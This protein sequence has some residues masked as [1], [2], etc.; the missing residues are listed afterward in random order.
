MA[1]EVESAAGA[2]RGEDSGACVAYVMKVFPRLSETFVLNEI[3]AVERLG[4]RVV[5]CSLHRPPEEL[6]HGVLSELTSPVHYIEDCEP[7]SDEDVLAALQ[8]LQRRFG[9]TREERK[10]FL[11][12]KYVRLALSLRSLLDASGVE[13]VHAHF[14]SRAGHVSAI[15]AALS[16]VPYSI[17]A[18]AKDIYHD[19]VD[20]EVLAWKLRSARFVVTVSDY[21]LRHLR[22]LLGPQDGARVRR[23]Y[24]GVDLSRFDAVPFDR[25]RPG[26]ILGVGRLVEKKGFAVLVDACRILRDRGVAFSCEII[27]G[28]AEE[29]GLRKQIESARLGSRVVLTGAVETEQVAERMALASVLAL[30][31]VEGRDGNVDALPTVLLEAMA[32]ARPVVSTRL[33]GIPEIVDEG[34]TGLLV[35]PGDAATLADALQS[36]LED[37]ARAVQMGLFGRERAERLFDL[38]RNACEVGRFFR[39]NDERRGGQ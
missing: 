14:A 17:T 19:D 1:T 35:E 27:G 25:A 31:C 4:T 8:G 6:R 39:E 36:V 30:P 18:H 3:R 12:R 21:N 23:V 20:R 37:R 32:R 5:V 7:P 9:W 2:A 11:P 15:A 33:S 16:G 38:D 34:V 24:N 13:H 28:G 22:R 26:R 29:A 10:K